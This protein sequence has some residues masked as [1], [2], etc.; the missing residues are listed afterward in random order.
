MLCLVS[1]TESAERDCNIKYIIK[2]YKGKKMKYHAAVYSSKKFYQQ[3]NTFSIP[4][5]ML[6]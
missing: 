6:P 5:D 4:H 3:N 2:I 1:L